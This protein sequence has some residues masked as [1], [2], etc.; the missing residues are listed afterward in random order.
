MRVYLSGPMRGLT[1]LNRPAF[2]LAAARLHARGHQVYNPVEEDTSDDIRI[3]L[4]DDLEWILARAEAVVVLDGW[5]NSRGACAEVFT[6]W[7]VSVPVVTLSDFLATG[8]DG[9]RLCHA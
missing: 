2:N 4:A 5:Q 1:D 3:N 9:P 7:A 8:L 6:A